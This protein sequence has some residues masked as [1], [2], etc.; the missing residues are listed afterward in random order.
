MITIIHALHNNNCQQ[1][2][3]A[4][5]KVAIFSK[6]WCPYSKKV[7]QLF[8]DN[9]PE[10]KPDVHEYILNSIVWALWHV[11]FTHTFS[12]FFSLYTF[13]LDERDDGASIQQYLL[14]KTGQRTVPNVFVSEYYTIAGFFFTDA[15]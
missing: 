9:F 2:S 12:F 7:K 13:R 10:V 8:A 3:I 1:D 4:G 14:E 6:S 15:H 5:H 11:M